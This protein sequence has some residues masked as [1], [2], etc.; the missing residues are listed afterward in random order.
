MQQ[1]SQILD[2]AIGLASLYL[3]LSLICSALVES[4]E[5]WWSQ[6]RSR[7]LSEG[8]QEL[9]GGGADALK[10]LASF[11]NSPLIFGLYKG[12]VK[13]ENNQLISDGKGANLPSYIDPKLFSGALIQ[14]ILNGKALDIATLQSELAASGLP[15]NVQKSLQILIDTAGNDVNQAIANIEDWYTAMTDR[16]SG[17]YKRHTQLVAFCMAAALTVAGNFDSVAIGKSLMLNES[18]RNKVV[19]NALALNAQNPT[20]NSH[21]CSS[22]PESAQCRDWLNGQL[23]T[24]QNLGMPVGWQN[25]SCPQGLAGFTE[26]LLGWLMTI[27]AV[28]LGAPFWFDLLNKFV[29]IRS[30][31]KP[32]PA[33]SKPEEKK[34]DTAKVPAAG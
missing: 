24:L 6:R 27:I 8:L 34:S 30:T 3:L 1:T 2:V 21:Q 4:L 12:K 5:K 16:V 7:H 11:Y 25:A 23:M 20:A 19:E 29:N 14:Q 33:I 22:D 31:L 17:W 13:I 10:F 28:S 26:K 9:F 32:S 18:L 15:E